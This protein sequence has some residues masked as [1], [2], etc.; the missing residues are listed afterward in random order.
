MTYRTS[1]LFR[2]NIQLRSLPKFLDQF[3]T[4]KTMEGKA[5]HLQPVL[6]YLAAF[7]AELSMTLTR[8]VY[9]NPVILLMFE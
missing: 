4:K 9:F 8:Y 1:Y 2:M 6:T 5:R 3:K 7:N